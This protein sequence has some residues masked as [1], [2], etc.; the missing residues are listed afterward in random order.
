MMQIVI[1][2]TGKPGEP[3]TFSA[4][5]DQREEWVRWNQERDKEIKS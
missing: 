1:P 2:P 5:E 3:V 4:E